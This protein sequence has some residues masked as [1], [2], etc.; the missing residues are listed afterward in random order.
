M[1]ASKGVDT[2]KKEKIKKLKLKK[3][4]KV[5]VIYFII[6]LFILKIV[7]FRNIYNL[8]AF[9]SLYC[10]NLLYIIALINDKK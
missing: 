9:I 5:C 8:L 4:I 7:N 10:T 6:A 1:Q 3:D 2:M